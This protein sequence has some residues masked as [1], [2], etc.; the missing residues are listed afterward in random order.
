M[1]FRSVILACALFAGGAS[2]AEARG[3][4][5]ANAVRIDQRGGS[6]GAAVVQTGASA[7]AAVDQHGLGHSAA[8]VQTGDANSAL[9]RQFGQNNS[10]AITQS[11]AGNAACVLQVGRNVSAQIAQTGNQSAGIIQTSRGAREV[12][13]DVCAGARL[14]RGGVVLGAAIPSGRGR[15]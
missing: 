13:V 1:R 9:I 11:G 12:P 6:H 7:F 3:G 4:A 14:G 5:L 10:A 15:W 2:V 8:V